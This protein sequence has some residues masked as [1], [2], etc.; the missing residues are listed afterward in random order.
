MVIGVVVYLVLVLHRE[1]LKTDADE[2]SIE[3][4]GAFVIAKIKTI[5]TNS[6]LIF[7]HSWRQRAIVLQQSGQLRQPTKSIEAARFLTALSSPARLSQ[8]LLSFLL[9][10]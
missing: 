9:S 4:F 10:W 2:A 7:Y 3:A 1:C 6:I 5:T 8:L